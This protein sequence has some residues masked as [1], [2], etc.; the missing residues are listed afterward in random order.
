MRP[1]RT[2]LQAF[3]SR[4]ALPMQ[5][6]RLSGPYPFKLTHPIA[7]PKNPARQNAASK[8]PASRCTFMHQKTSLRP[9]YHF[10]LPAPRETG[11]IR[12]ITLSAITGGTCR[13]LIRHPASVRRSGA[14]FHLFCPHSSQLMRKSCARPVPR[15]ARPEIPR[16]ALCAAECKCTLSVNAFC[17]FL[18]ALKKE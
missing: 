13:S 14:I 1:R 18:N 16:N 8:K 15:Q 5:A 10:S 7:L 9:C 11:L 12:S 2:S 4:C 17:H 3:A 6:S